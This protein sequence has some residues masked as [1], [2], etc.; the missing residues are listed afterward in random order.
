MCSDERSPSPGVSLNTIPED[1]IRRRLDTFLSPAEKEMV[2][3]V[4]AAQNPEDLKLFA[5]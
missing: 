3:K 1:Y 4:E 2:M 5:K